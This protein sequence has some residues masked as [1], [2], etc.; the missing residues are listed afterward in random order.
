MSS[1][2]ERNLFSSKPG[3]NFSLTTIN[4]HKQTASSSY[5]TPQCKKTSRNHVYDVMTRINVLAIKV[6]LFFRY[7]FGSAFHNKCL[8]GVSYIC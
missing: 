4:V 3:H 8:I 5:K 6:W 1:N 7:V 2:L